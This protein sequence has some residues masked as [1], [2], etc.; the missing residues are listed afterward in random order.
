MFQAN[1]ADIVTLDAG[2]VYSAVKQFDLV[3]IA[4]EMYADGRFGSPSSDTSP[5]LVRSE[6]CVCF[7]AGGCVLSVAVVT[8]RSLDIR[9]L[10]GLRSC[11]SG[12]RWTA[13]WSLP[14]GFLLSR[15]YLSWSK[16]HPLS[17]GS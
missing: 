10:Q 8:N 6:V 17:Q 13:G 5:Y 11:H 16:E 7:S 12:I 2:E 9:S 3:A 14:L 4:K 15:N 1:R